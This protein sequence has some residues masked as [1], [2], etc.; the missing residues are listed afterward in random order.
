[1]DIRKFRKAYDLTQVELSELLSITS[2]QVINFENN[3]KIPEKNFPAI[4]A[5]EKVCSRYKTF[6]ARLNAMQ[7]ETKRLKETY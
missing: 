5:I 4:L 1:M 7:R 2:R 3:G 6:N